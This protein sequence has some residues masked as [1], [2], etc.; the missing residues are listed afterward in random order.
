MFVKTLFKSFDW[1]QFLLVIA[2]LGI[3]LTCVMSATHT[4]LQLYSYLFKKQL[5]GSFVGLFFYFFLAA[6][7]LKTVSR[8]GYFA[9]GLAIA[10]LGYTYCRGF[11]AL[12]ARRWISFYFF[13]MQPS[14]L[15]K[16]L[17]PFFMGYFLYESFMHLRVSQSRSFWMIWGVPLSTLFFTFW[18]VKKQ[19]DLG[20][21]LL[22][23][24]QGLGILWVAGLSR[25]FFLYGALCCLFGAPLIFMTL[26][27]YQKQRL[28]VLCGYGEKH[29]E[30]YQVEQALIAIGSGGLTGKGFLQGTQN[31]FSFLPEDHS[32]LIFAI[33]C[34]EWGIIGAAVL[35]LLYFLLALRILWRLFNT[36][37]YLRHLVGI[38][39]LLHIMLAVLVNA[40]MVMGILPIVGVPLPLMSYGLSYLWVTL[41]SLGVLQ[42]E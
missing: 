21:A 20:T 32:D 11:V 33:L 22:I 13:R 18:L 27:P 26:K 42:G 41:A 24:F 12:G 7:P 19:P 10:L 28:Y 39:Q 35:F 9:Y 1:I 4:D 6:V 8:I 17:L 30:R 40:G 14:E 23:L 2:L 25:R 34:E 5:L 31:K 16:F 38:G 29:K 15:I 36:D 3:G 37:D